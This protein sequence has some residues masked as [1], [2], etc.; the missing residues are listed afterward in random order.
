MWR[1]RLAICRAEHFSPSARGRALK[2]HHLGNGPAICL[3]RVAG[4]V[5]WP[6]LVVCS[7]S[8][9]KHNKQCEPLLI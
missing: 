6:Y 1:R 5:C 4:F 8:P 2:N 7:I 3:G 9:K